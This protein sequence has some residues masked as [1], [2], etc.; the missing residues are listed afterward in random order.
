M[1]PDGEDQKSI[2]V[3]E[4][5]WKVLAKKEFGRTDA[6]IGI[7]GGATTDFAGFVAATWLRGIAWYAIP[8]T[9]AGMVDASVGGK[10][11][12]NTSAGKN[13]LGPSILRVKFAL[14]SHGLIHYQIA[15]FQQGLQ[16]LSKQVLL[17]IFLS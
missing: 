17:A 6:I 2:S 15:T 14:I 7:G 3:V 13:R 12:I 9:L 5:A 1:T 11:G 16:K 8:T 4:K 10:T